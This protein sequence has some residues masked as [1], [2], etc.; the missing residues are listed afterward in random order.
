MISDERNPFFTE[1]AQQTPEHGVHQE[2]P[3]TGLKRRH[4][5]PLKKRCE[6]GCG[7]RLDSP[8]RG[9]PRKYA[10]GACRTRAYRRRRAWPHRLRSFAT[11]L[12]RGKVPPPRSARL[13]R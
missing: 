12:I 5:T 2:S 13:G 1:K 10:T 4:V 9:T 11:R 3:S 7:A 8:G 6:C